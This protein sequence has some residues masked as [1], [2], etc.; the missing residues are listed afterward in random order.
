M[1]TKLLKPLLPYLLVVG[2]FATISVAYFVPEIFEDK[3]M[4]TT[5]G[6]GGAGAGREAGEHY[7]NTGEISRWTNGLFGGMP[8][9]QIAPPSPSWFRYAQRASGLFLPAPANYVFMLLFGSF[10]LF[11]AL[12]GDW[13]TAALGAVAYAFSSYFFIIIHAGHIWKVYV[14]AHI[15]PTF[16]GIIWAYRGKYLLG[17]ALAAVYS[18]LQLVSN[19]PQMSYYFGLLLSIYIVGQLIHDFRKRSLPRFVKASA[20]LVLAGFIAVALNS[21]NL[22]HSWEYSKYTMRG[23]SEL[24][25]GQDNQTQ[26]IDRDYA[27]SWSYGRGETFSLMIPNVKGGA[28]GYLNE[29]R[30]AV[31][32]AE[33]RF[34]QNVAQMNSYW[35][36]QPFTEGPVYVGAFVMF[37]FVLGLF[38][39][40]GRWKWILLSGTILSILLSWGHNFMWFTDLFLDYVPLYDKFRTVAS[41]LV[42]AELTIPMLAILALIKIVKD[43]GVIV[44]YERGFYISLGFT[45]GLT[46]LFIAYPRLFSFVSKQELDYFTENIRANASQA[47]VIHDFINSLETVRISIF[48]SDAWRSFVII[49]VGAGAIW[50]F[51]RRRMK[52]ILFLTLLAVLI[53]FDM[54]VINKRYLNSRD[55]K[56]RPKIASNLFPKTAAD[57]E[58]LKDTTLGY[59]VYNRAVNTFNDASTSFYHRSVGG[60]HAAKMRRYQDLIERHLTKMNPAVIN[61][62]NTKYIIVPDNDQVRAIRNDKALGVAWFVDS[63]KWVNSP[64]EEI[65]ALDDFDPSKTAVIDRRFEAIVPKNLSILTDSS[66]YIRMLSYAPNHLIYESHLDAEKLAVFSEIYYAHGW[67]SYIDGNELPHLRANYV[68]RAMPIPEGKHRIEF[69]FDPHSFHVTTTAANVASIVLLLMLLFVIVMEILRKKREQEKATK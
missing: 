59:R 24:T 22:Y 44:K 21:S 65:A 56:P 49:L 25:V 11:L 29:N 3:V 41:I 52:S 45:A 28:T 14:L 46:L 55:F 12:G 34:R 54:S 33:S 13:R 31:A 42:I 9:Y 51:A 58:I 53:M 26:G 37:L 6:L 7:A 18:A 43:P 20:M 15:P 8:T 32:K 66:A 67:R 60:Y 47:S 69:I 10:L 38:I 27:T 39:V 2:I 50:F 16:A 35:G 64:D 5:D 61:M 63:V 19:H 48:R 1:N 36:D 40:R 23:P 62:L 30:G 68:L 17:G 57:E 4:I